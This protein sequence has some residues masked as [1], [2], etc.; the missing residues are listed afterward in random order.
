VK[1]F[2]RE[3]GVFLLK[4]IGSLLVAL[5]AISLVTFVIVRRAGTPVYLMVGDDFTKEMVESANRRLGLDKPIYIQYLHYLGGILR[6]DLGV[7]RFT[8]NPVTVDI[9]NR[10]PATL[11]LATAALLMMI[12]WGVPAGVLSAVKEHTL[13]DRAILTVPK[14]G[15]SATQFWLGLL[16]IYF[17]YFRLGWFPEPSGRLP[18]SAVA[19]PVVT[20]FLT[21][22]SLLAGDTRSFVLAV[23]NLF[24]PAFTLAFT[25]SP[26][27]LLITR[28]T[29][30]SILKTDYVRT[31]RA[32][33]LPKRLLF[34]KYIFR[35]A[36]PPVL[37]VLAIAYG[38]FIGGTVLVEVVFSWPGIGRYAV[39]ALSR[40]DFEPIVALVLLSSMA[41]A[42]VFLL[43]DILNAMMDPRYRLT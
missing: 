34:T 17:L 13:I 26:G 32:F 39:D 43:T 9:A 6:G 3:W 36:V 5:L 4:R 38:S 20:G 16:L 19:P 41:Y 15:V 40:S 31:A 18:M 2:L 8:F 29:I 12:L 22:D 10:L 21:I 35:N 24:L 42:V 30:R 23:R 7:S 28:A 33:G 27:T 37:T 11:E 1:E 25:I 14:L